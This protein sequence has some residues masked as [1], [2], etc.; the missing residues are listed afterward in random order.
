ME[1]S[2]GPQIQ[3]L[4]KE[5]DFSTKLNFAERKAWKALH[6]VCRNFIGNENAENYRE[7]VQ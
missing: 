1:I 6:N 2:V 3:R 7:I 5:Q 4:F